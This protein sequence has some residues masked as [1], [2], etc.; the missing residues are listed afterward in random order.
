[1]TNSTLPVNGGAM[2]K[3]DRSAIMA[4]AWAIFRQTYCYPCI[5]FASIGWKC[6]ASCLRAA[7]AE[8]RKA[9]KIAAMAPAAKAA[10]IIEQPYAQLFAE[11]LFSRPAAWL[12]TD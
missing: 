9:M 11:V 5:T 4:R 8:A 3:P 2:P 10:R 7:W 1:M 12:Q 6:F